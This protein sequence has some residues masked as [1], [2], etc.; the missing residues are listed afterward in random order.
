MDHSSGESLNDLQRTAPAI[1]TASV[2]EALQATL[3]A[4]HVK[5][6]KEP[7]IF[8]SAEGAF[9]DNA[10]FVSPTPVVVDA[11]ILRNDI[12]YACRRNQRTVLVTAANAQL[13]RLFCAQHVVDEVRE[14]AEK[15]TD[16][17]KVSQ[18]AFLDR[19]IFEYL[20]VIRVVQTDDIIPA[21][22]GPQER[23]RIETLAEIDPDDLP[24][25]VLA[26]VLEAFYLSEDRSP[27]QAVYGH[28]VDLAAHHEWVEAL[29]AGGDAGE[30]GRM[31]HFFVWVFAPLVGSILMPLKI[32]VT[33]LRWWSLVA[34]AL[35]SGL[36]IKY[37]SP[38][39]KHSIRSAASSAGKALP[40]ALAVCHDVFAVYRDLLERLERTAPSVPSWDELATTN[41]NEAVLLRACL[42]TL[43]RS[44]MSDRSARELAD[45]LP[46]LAVAQGETKVRYIL[47]SH[48]CFFEVWRG[49]W[50]VG[51]VAALLRVHLE[52]SAHAHAE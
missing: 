52:Q 6:S 10:F 32:L 37:T 1:D 19:W 2:I 25:A 38:E 24:S 30:L 43:A 15:W 47:R 46:A 26:L 39:V 27:L 50:Q 48:D 34:P 5:S 41:G 40:P 31:F 35:A 16:G 49:R 17:P 8:P 13:L 3:H 42:H 18:A 12:L 44:P 22:L 36:A 21:L 23:S 20:P 51:E 7:I 28:D 11:N 9:A 29:K 14:H 45:A 4:A 33:R